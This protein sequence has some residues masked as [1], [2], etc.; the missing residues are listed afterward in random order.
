MLQHQCAQ[1]TNK[2]VQFVILINI[3]PV[4]PAAIDGM[5]AHK[6]GAVQLVRATQLDW[7]QY[8]HNSEG[9]RKHSETCVLVRQPQLEV[10][11]RT[12]TGYFEIELAGPTCGGGRLNG[13]INWEHFHS[14]VD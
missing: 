11:A 14:F 10:L 13:A 8:V 1:K 7:R 5:F 12:G 9:L 2:R 3:V 6:L 4:R